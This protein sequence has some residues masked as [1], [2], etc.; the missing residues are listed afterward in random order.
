MRGGRVH[1]SFQLKLLVPVVTETPLSSCPLKEKQEDGT[2][3][4]Q[5]FE[6]CPCT[7]KEQV[8]C[9]VF[10]MWKDF[11]AK[12]RNEST[13]GDKKYNRGTANLSQYIIFY[14]AFAINCEV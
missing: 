7:M 3:R 14:W 6:V 11:E 5:V 13:G 1:Y 4:N 8:A 2:Q 10:V 9:M 12:E